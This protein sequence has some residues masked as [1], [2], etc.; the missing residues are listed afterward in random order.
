M[1]D[2]VIDSCKWY[3]DE[4]LPEEQKNELTEKFKRRYEPLLNF[5]KESGLMIMDKMDV[6][7][8]QSFEIKMSDFTDE[9]LELLMLCHDRWLDA[10]ERGLNPSNI[11]LWKRELDKLRDGELCFH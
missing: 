7:D 8:W 1:K 5:F 10:M 2:M 6:E 9:G 4:G 3:L 11:T